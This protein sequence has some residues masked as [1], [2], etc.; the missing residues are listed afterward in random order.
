MEKLSVNII[1]KHL[2]QYNKDARKEFVIS[3]V[4]K[5]KKAEALKKMKDLFKNTTDKQT[6][7][8]YY[9]PKNDSID[10]DDK[11]YKKIFV[12]KKKFKLK[13]KEKEAPVKKKEAPAKKK[14]EPKKKEELDIQQ[15]ILSFEFENKNWKQFLKDFKMGKTKFGG[16]IKLEDYEKNKIKLKKLLEKTEKLGN[17]LVSQ[18]IKN[19]SDFYKGLVKTFISERNKITRIYNK[20]KTRFNNASYL[21]DYG[22]VDPKKKEAPKKKPK[23]KIKFKIV[24]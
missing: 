10:V 11:D 18:N 8:T 6:G 15:D 19:E 23:K 12:E 4:S 16:K 5:M 13:I 17:K 3:G 24:N 22:G 14:E 20:A 1:K 21:L 9:T 7:N 2:V